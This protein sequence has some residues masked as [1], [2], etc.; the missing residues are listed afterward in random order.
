MSYVHCPTCQ[1]AYH[2]GRDKTCPRCVALAPAC[3]ER[4]PEREPEPPRPVDP[5]ADIVL[6]ATQLARALARATPAQRDA[7][8]ASLGLVRDQIATSRATDARPA[9]WGLRALAATAVARTP[10]LATAAI[11]L[12]A[13]RLLR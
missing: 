12:I 8:R 3:D 7:A 6:A 2:L 9:R 13:R 5:I 1:R 4:R 11:T 10:L